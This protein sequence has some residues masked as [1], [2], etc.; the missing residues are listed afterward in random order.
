MERLNQHV[1]LELHARFQMKVVGPEGCRAALPEGIE[2][3]EV[4]VRPL[5]RFL[6][7]AMIRSLWVGH[8]KRPRVV[9][10]GS[11]L[12]APIAVLS[13]WLAG[14][15]SVVYA[16]GLDLVARH[17]L[18]RAVWLPFLR[19]CDVCVVNSRHTAGLAERT[20]VSAGKITIIHPGVT[21][22]DGDDLG[23]GDSFRRE[24]GLDGSKLLLSVGRLTPRKGLL[25]FVRDALPHIVKDHPDAVLVVIGDEAPDA[26]NGA[27][28]GGAATIQELAYGL[29][30][31]RHVRMLGAC[32]DAM[33]SSAYAAADLC[34][35]PLRE[36]PGDVEGFGMVAVEAAAHGLPTVAFDVGGVADAVANGRSGWLVPAGDYPAMVERIHQVFMVG[37]TPDARRQAQDFARAFDWGHFGS[38]LR[39]RVQELMTQGAG[40]P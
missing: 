4:P 29:G 30:L 9:I 1:A 20:G 15:R 25:E 40:T 34:V 6:M 39:K 19:R 2:V 12:T 18:Y 16:H 22:P 23:N 28:I 7:Q 3:Y 26:L 13:A 17:R 27:G 14:G 24:H 5:W 37:R 11:G 8:R 21:L 36:I 10:A 32:S 33:L 38:R 35:F 31:D